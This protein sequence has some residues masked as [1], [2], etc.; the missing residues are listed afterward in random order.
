MNGVGYTF[1]Y[2]LDSELRKMYWGAYEVET[3]W[4]MEQFLKPGDIF[5]DV[6]AN[7]GFISA[8]GAG[9]VGK[10][11]EVH[12]FEP[13]PTYFQRLTDFSTANPD[14]TIRT[15]PFALGEKPGQATIQINQNNN[16][17][18][19]TMVPGFM[20]PE[21]RKE[22]ISVP[23]RRLDDFIQEELIGHIALIKIDTEGFEL[24]VLKGLSHYLTHQRP[25]IICEIAPRAYPLQGHSLGELKAYMS[26]FSYRAY[27]IVDLRTEVELTRLTETYTLVF[28]SSRDRN[29]QNPG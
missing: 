11:G 4:A 23:V 17:G 8:V 20:P 2:T 16:I 3:V 29:G 27:S 14:Y 28:R 21:D 1:D 22:S 9:L 13:V 18:W 10:T 7:I 6:G 19:N 12:S 26:E 15:H 24:P 5:M 25:P